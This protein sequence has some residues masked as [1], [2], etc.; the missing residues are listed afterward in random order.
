[1][2]LLYRDTMSKAMAGFTAPP[3]L[4]EM[5]PVKQAEKV[6]GGGLHTITLMRYWSIV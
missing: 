1:M 5:F 3:D 2:R 6:A 4:N